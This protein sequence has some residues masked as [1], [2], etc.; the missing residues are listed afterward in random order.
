MV[1]REYS[2]SRSLLRVSI[3][4][5]SRRVSFWLS[6]ATAWICCDCLTRSAAA[7]WS[8]RHPIEDWLASSA[9][10]TAP[11]EAAPHDPSRHSVV[12]SSSSSSAKNPVSRPPVFSAS[13]L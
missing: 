2:R 4:E 3:A 10:I 7:T 12:R 11:T 13:K 9:T 1:T 5:A 6:L 8:R